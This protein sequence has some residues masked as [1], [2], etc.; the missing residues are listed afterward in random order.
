MLSLHI[1]PS[2]LEDADM[3]PVFV[4]THAVVRP[5]GLVMTVRKVHMIY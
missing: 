3:D 4:P 5:G 2:V 1:Q